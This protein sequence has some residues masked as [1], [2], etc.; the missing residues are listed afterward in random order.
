MLHCLHCLLKLLWPVTLSRLSLS[1]KKTFN[2]VTCKTSALSQVY[3]QFTLQGGTSDNSE[4]KETTEQATRH[5][6]TGA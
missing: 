6:E 1:S 3:S 5:S 4:A 2:R